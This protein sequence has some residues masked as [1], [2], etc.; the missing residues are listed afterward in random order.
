MKTYSVDDIKDISDDEFEVFGDPS[1]KSVV[2]PACITE[3]GPQDLCWVSSTHPR[4]HGYLNTT[5][6]EIIIA[7]D[8]L[9]LGDIGEKVVL[10]TSNPKLA[11]LKLVEQLF[12]PKV[13]YGIHPSAVIHPEADISRNCLIGPNTYIGKAIIGSDTIIFGNTHIYDGVKIGSRVTIEAGVVIGATGF[14]FARDAEGRLHKFPHLGGVVIEDDVDIQAMSV[15][16]RGVLVDT[17]IGRGTKID[18]HVYIAHNCQLGEDNMIIGHT[19]LSGSVEVGSRCW[20]APASV[21]RDAISAGDDAFIGMGSVVTRSVEAG[22][23]VMGNPARP[24]AEV[25]QRQAAVKA[26]IRNP[27]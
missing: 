21:F 20:V 12:A 8:D 22:E 19:M 10:K 9:D 14:N 13:E 1:G 6:A 15:I 16:D 17:V 27:G 18:S 26:L 25:K 2:K 3:A 4:R 11:Y 23:A 5:K 7:G 24:V